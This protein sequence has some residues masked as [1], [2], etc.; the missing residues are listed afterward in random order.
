[1]SSNTTAIVW[2]SE[3]RSWNYTTFLIEM[4]LHTVQN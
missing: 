2:S 1:M 4:K 3:T